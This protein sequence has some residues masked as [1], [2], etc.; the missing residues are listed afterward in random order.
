MRVTRLKYGTTLTE[1]RSMKLVRS[2]RLKHFTSQATEQSREP[3]TRQQERERKFIYA[4]SVITPTSRRIRSQ[5]I[6]VVLPVVPALV[7]V[8]AA[9]PVV[10]AGVGEAPAVAAQA[11][12]GKILRTMKV[13]VELRRGDYACGRVGVNSPLRALFAFEIL[14]K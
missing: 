1:I 7:P 14:S 5:S 4:N 6:R 12:V 10:A 11:A 2:V 3:V 13:L 9:L 8:A